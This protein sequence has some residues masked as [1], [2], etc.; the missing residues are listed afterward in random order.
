MALLDLANPSRFLALVARVQP[1]LI[2]ATVAM[3]A[4]AAWQ[5][6]FVSPDDYQQGDT[7]S[8]VGEDGKFERT[9]GNKLGADH[10]RTVGDS[11]GSCPQTIDHLGVPG[12]GHHRH[13]HPRPG[14]VHLPQIE[15]SLSAHVVLE[16]SSPRCALLSVASGEYS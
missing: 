5:V 3:F 11:G 8:V 2:A 16:V 10:S 15:R 9:R 7:V 4:V 14:G 1:W 6:F 13:A 12:R